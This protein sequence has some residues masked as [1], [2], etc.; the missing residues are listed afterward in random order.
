ML[1]ADVR[2]LGV[3]ALPLSKFVESEKGFS[4]FEL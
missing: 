2:E 4:K 1:S 3:I